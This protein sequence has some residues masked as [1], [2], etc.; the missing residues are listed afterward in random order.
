MTAEIITQII[1]GLGGR[2]TIAPAAIEEQS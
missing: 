1:R 2:V